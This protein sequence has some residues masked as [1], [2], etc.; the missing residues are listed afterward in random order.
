MP[1]WTS[2]AD[3]LKHLKG[4]YEPKTRLALRLLF[5][6]MRSAANT[7]S[8]TFDSSILESSFEKCCGANDCYNKIR[9]RIWRWRRGEA[10]KILINTNRGGVMTVVSFLSLCLLSTGTFFFFFFFFFP[11][12]Q[13]TL[14]HNKHTTTDARLAL[15]STSR[16]GR[17]RWAFPHLPTEPGGV[18]SKT[19]TESC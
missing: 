2:I 18:L 10:R 9:P 13:K 16:R 11:E 14:T 17:L 15:H 12:T 3:S 4:K 8:P 1:E 19:T 7:L 5:L 6:R